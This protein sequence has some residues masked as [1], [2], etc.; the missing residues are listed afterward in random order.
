MM[1]QIM[2]YTIHGLIVLRR[3]R[4]TIENRS[5]KSPVNADIDSVRMIGL[6]LTNITF[7]LTGIVPI[8]NEVYAE[9]KVEIEYTKVIDK[10]LKASVKPVGSKISVVKKDELLAKYQRLGGAYFSYNIIP[11]LADID[12]VLSKYGL[13]ENALFIRTMFFVGQHES[14]WN[15]HSVSGS[16]VGTEHPTGLFQFLP[17]TF[18]TVSAGNIFSAH[19]QIEAF[20]TM[21][22]RGR[23]DEFGTLYIGG[24]D[25]AV[26]GFALS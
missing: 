5:W 17:S 13:D 8:S 3:I 23:L 16:S 2:T 25:P 6:I 9:E 15:I 1:N 11:Y 24:L 22:L 21:Y 18:R 10:K 26:K 20:V 19:D 4:K 7:L 14:H 12:A